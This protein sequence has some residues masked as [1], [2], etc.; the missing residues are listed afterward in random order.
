LEVHKNT[1]SLFVF[2]F[3]ELES[4]DC[5]ETEAAAAKLV[6]EYKDYLDQILGVELVQFPAFFTHF[7]EGEN[8]QRDHFLYK[9]LMNKK[10]AGTFQNVEMILQIYLVLMVTN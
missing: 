3:C 1:C 5:D 6:A 8:I 9:L 7:P 4:L 10:I 2:F